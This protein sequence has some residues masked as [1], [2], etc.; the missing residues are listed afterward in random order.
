MKIELFS[1]RH[2]NK[3]LIED[4]YVINRFCKV[5]G[6][7]DGATPITPFE[8]EYGRNGAHLASHI[9]SDHF[10][11][12]NRMNDLIE[13]IR[14]AN[15]SLKSRMQR[16]NVPVHTE[17]EPWSTCV[18]MI[19][20]HNEM[21]HYAALGDSL[22]L[23]SFKNGDIRLI[24]RDTVQG[25]SKRM[26]AYRNQERERGIAL[27]SES[28]YEDAIRNH[29]YIRNHANRSY[30]YTVANGSPE[31]LD[32]IQ[33][34][35]LAI[36]EINQILLITDGLIPPSRNW[37]KLF[38]TINTIGLKTYGESLFVYEPS[39]SIDDQTG[40]MLSF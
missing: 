21:I 4:S 37:L 38:S 7:F 28:Y 13:E 40:I 31:T 22:I 19:H 5:Y 12:L 20:I 27:P 1:K 17:Q 15:A 9:F 33:S 29:L 10:A 34:G 18:A 11:N 26:V 23:A 14:L 35:T 8:D 6:V 30:S 25:I 16:Y 32:F 24:T 2:P 39:S 3:K 36:N